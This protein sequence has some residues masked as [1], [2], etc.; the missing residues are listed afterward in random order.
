MAVFRCWERR[1]HT[2][3]KCV[4]AKIPI[5]EPTAFQSE[6]AASLLQWSKS[7]TR[8][9]LS[10]DKCIALTTD[11]WTSRATKSFMTITAHYI[12]EN[13]VIKNPVLQTRT[14]YESHT[15][16]YLSEILQGAVAEW[17]IDRENVT[18]P[19]T[20]REKC[21]ILTSLHWRYLFHFCLNSGMLTALKSSYCCCCN[22]YWVKWIYCSLA[23][24]VRWHE[25]Y[26]HSKQNRTEPWL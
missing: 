21:F 24:L 14:V 4:G 25:P 15:S 10:N 26:P 12:T 7:Q 22:Y 18:I 20:T 16:D 6:C 11:G 5:T 2:F 1:I 13:W 8:D 19:V 23:L 3:A 9:D 17:K